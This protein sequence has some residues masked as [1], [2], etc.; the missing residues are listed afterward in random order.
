[1][2]ERHHRELQPCRV[3]GMKGTTSSLKDL[4]RCFCLL[5]FCFPASGGRPCIPPTIPSH[6]L[7]PPPTA[8]LAETV[9]DIAQSS[10]PATD[11]TALRCSHILD[12]ALH[13]R[14]PRRYACSHG[15]R[16]ASPPLCCSSFHSVANFG[17]SIPTIFSSFGQ[18]Q[19]PI[20]SGGFDYGVS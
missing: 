5:I 16:A 9:L 18:P 4:S 2:S 19:N 20:A 6:L 12:S 17:V 13:S 8:S 3:R 10:W 7:C 11:G 14:T 15:M 1:M